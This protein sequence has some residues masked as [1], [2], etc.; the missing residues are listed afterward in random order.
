M[1]SFQSRFRDEYLNRSNSGL[2]PKRAS[3]SKSSAMILHEFSIHAYAVS[4]PAFT[5]F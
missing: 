2:R 3:S 5:V 4:P 1:K